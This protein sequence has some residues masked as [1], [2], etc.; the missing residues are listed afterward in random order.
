MKN[1]NR[2]KKYRI[3]YPNYLGSCLFN[4]IFRVEVQYPHSGVLIDELFNCVLLSA[5][6]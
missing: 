3:R 5:V 6:W 2:H 1:R 4:E